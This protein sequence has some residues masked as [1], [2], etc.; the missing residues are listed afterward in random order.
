MPLR[1]ALAERA[2]PPHDAA[3]P[4]DGAEAILVGNIVAG[5]ERAATLERQLRHERLDG[6]ALVGMACMKL[7]DHLAFQEPQ[8]PARSCGEGPG[9]VARLRLAMRGAAIV[10]G[11]R[12]PLVFETQSQIPRGEI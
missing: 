11:E 6:A 3:Q 4:P 10:Q 2:A 1:R 12:Q 5:E 9:E 8:R 7:D